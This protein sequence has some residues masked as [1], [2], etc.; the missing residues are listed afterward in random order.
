MEMMK[1]IYLTLRFFWILLGLATLFI[2]A[3][4]LDIFFIPA[5]ILCYGFILYVILDI[6]FLF[7]GKGK[8]EIKR[9]YPEKLS[10]GDENELKIS[11]ESHFPFPLRARVLE[12]FP[13]Q[14]QHRD[15]S[16]MLL[17][18]PGE[19]EDIHYSLRPTKRGR[20]IFGNCNVLVQYLGLIERRFRL[21]E[22]HIL[23]CY[24]SFIQLRKY[25]LLATTNRLTEVGVKKIRRIGHTME[26]DQI[27][28]YVPGDDYRLINWKATA[29]LHKVMINQYQEE[30]SQPIY[31]VID[32]SRNMRM[33]FNGMSLLDYAI[34]SS[35]VLSN[36][37]ILKHDRAGLL[38]FSDKI[39]THIQA[40]RNNQQMLKISEAL[41]HIDTEYKEAEYGQLYTHIRHRISQR[42]LLFLYTNFETM[43]SMLRQL[44]YLHLLNKSHILVVVIFKNTELRQMV[45]TPADKLRPIYN[46][47]IAEKL[48]YE[49]QLITQ[50]LQ[51]RGI[52]TILTE[53][54]NLTIDSINKYLEIK[55]RGLI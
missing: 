47:I 6:V 2:V 17:L 16:F 23:P 7:R 36:I 13:V 42:S 26:F 32:L 25:R 12:E 51:Q 15:F 46:Q 38:T 37:S 18:K 10:N 20:Y 50:K 55:A 4:F 21:Q 53:P 11:L 41:Y 31:S 3:F 1:N 24:P 35:L 49:K 40:L 45:D 39:S 54:E 9:I 19:Q 34:N 28:E 27:K 43:D 30:K 29:K 14:F 44:R 5:I 33:P 52:H 8:V 22:E 48:L